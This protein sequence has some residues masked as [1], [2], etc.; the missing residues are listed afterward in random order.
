MKPGKRKRGRRQD[1]ENEKSGVGLCHSPCRL[2]GAFDAVSLA[3]KQKICLRT[4]LR[5]VECPCYPFKRK[6]RPTARRGS[7]VSKANAVRAAS[8]QHLPRGA[9]LGAQRQLYNPTNLGEQEL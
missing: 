3:R 8:E 9:E 4:Q 1:F 2:A 6:S 7:D 5:R